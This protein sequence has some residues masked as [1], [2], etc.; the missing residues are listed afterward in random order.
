MLQHDDSLLSSKVV[1]WLN[2]HLKKKNIK[3]TN[4][5]TDL[6]DGLN[7]IYALEDCTGESIRKCLRKPMVPL[8]MLEN[9]NNALTFLTDK[10]V[11]IG[12][13]ASNGMMNQFATGGCS[14]STN[15]PSNIFRY[16]R[17]KR[18]HD[19]GTLLAHSARLSRYT[20]S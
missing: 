3:V 12:S 4:L 20:K 13:V 1:E 2:H 18:L 11:H 16:P 6:S 8:F 19:P 14:V 5:E 15:Q 9:I 10:G 17:G 7:L